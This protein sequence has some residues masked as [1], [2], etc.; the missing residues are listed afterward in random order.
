MATKKDTTVFAT[1]ALAKARITELF[2]DF[3]EAEILTYGTPATLIGGIEFTVVHQ[4][5][6][7]FDYDTESETASYHVF[8]VKTNEGPVY[9]KINLYYTS[10]EGLE[11]KGYSFTEPK[12]KTVVV[13]E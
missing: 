6:T 11:V 5:R 7:S 1:Q 4:G 13:F 2:R 3:S 10:Y 9:V 8:S 12:E